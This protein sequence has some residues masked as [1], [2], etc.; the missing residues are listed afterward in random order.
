MPLLAFH[1]WK[2]FTM[3]WVRFSLLFYLVSHHNVSTQINEASFVL[4]FQQEIRFFIFSPYICRR[5]FGKT[6]H[7]FIMFWII[8]YCKSSLWHSNDSLFNSS[9]H[10]T[11]QA[12]AIF[13]NM[14]N[15]LQHWFK[16]GIVKWIKSVKNEVVYSCRCTGWLI[17]RFVLC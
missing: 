7:F 15:N 13:T 17:I 6:T 5:H 1:R 11:E 3:T 12:F 2:T 4:T 9:I 14:I 10:L 8:H 16:V